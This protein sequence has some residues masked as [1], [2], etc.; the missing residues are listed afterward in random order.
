MAQRVVT[1]VTFIDDL[2]GSEY[3][4]GEG[5]TFLYTWDGTAYEIDLSEANAER[6]RE[7]MAPW[8]AASRRATSAGPTTTS[9]PGK[10][11]RRKRAEIIAIR[12]WGRA[13][14]FDVPPIGGGRTPEA[15]IRA[16]DE[17]HGTIR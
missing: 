11:R 14:G 2:D 9:T 17:A 6:F 10:Q 5:E 3:Q 1:I 12:E 8:V 13:Q 7:A 15:V 4:E 16:Y